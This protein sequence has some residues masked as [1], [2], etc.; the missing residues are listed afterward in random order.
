MPRSAWIEDSKIPE[1]RAKREQ[2]DFLRY[3]N[4][5]GHIAD[6]HALRHTFITNL[7][8]GGVHPKLAQ[9]LARHCDVN[10][11]LS[12][13]SHTVISERATA[14]RSL[15]DLAITP[16]GAEPRDA[17]GASLTAARRLEEPVAA[18]PT[19]PTEN[20]VLLPKK[21]QKQVETATLS[22][23]FACTLLTV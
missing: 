17:N 7:A 16:V 5:V 4:S 18:P 9:D 11:T 14:L 8:R 21:P 12:R 3:E 22:M 13:Y 2:S 19:P 6:F 15:P 1:E 20:P 23:Y 10:L